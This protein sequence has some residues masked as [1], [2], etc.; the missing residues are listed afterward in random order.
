MISSAQ[1]LLLWTPRVLTIA[2]A[3]FLSL[4]SLD[5]FGDGYRGWQLLLA[6]LIHL[7]P[8]AIICMVLAL[9]WRWEWVGAF[10]F[11]GLGMYYWFAMGRHLSW[12][13][14]IS[15]PLFLVAALFFVNWLLRA[16][17]HQH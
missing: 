5:V 9:A 10:L 3:V 16:R 4:F 15:G 13:L 14:T 11:A 6:L 8:A 7:I 1:N 2:F 17:L 12:V